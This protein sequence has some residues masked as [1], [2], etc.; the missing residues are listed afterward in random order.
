[1][2]NLNCSPQDFDDVPNL[3]C[4]R[5][6]HVWR[7]RPA[8][9]GRSGDMTY[10]Y[11]NG[12]LVLELHV[13]LRRVDGEPCNFCAHVQ[14]LAHEIYHGLP[15]SGGQ[16]EIKLPF[17]DLGQ[18]HAEQSVLVKIIEVAEQAQQGREGW[19]PSVVRLQPLDFCLHSQVQR[20]DSPRL[21]DESIG[22]ISNRE[23]QAPFLRGRALSAFS[24]GSGVDEMVQSRSEVVNAIS[25][26]ARPYDSM[27]QE[28]VRSG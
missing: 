6:D 26:N 13:R 18:N 2:E 15:A 3:V 23:L 16:V 7:F 11:Y 9:A 22:A 17:T 25:D 28:T 8:V 10:S 1:M 14:P 4:Q 27:V 19:V 21:F 12:S 20:L 24:D 5:V